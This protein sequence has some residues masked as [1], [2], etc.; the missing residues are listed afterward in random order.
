M[1]FPFDGDPEILCRLIFAGRNHH[2]WLF[3]GCCWNSWN[4][5]QRL[6]KLSSDGGTLSQFEKKKKHLKELH[7]YFAL[8]GEEWRGVV[9]WLRSIP[10]HFFTLPFIDEQQRRGSGA[11]FFSISTFSFLVW[12]TKRLGGGG[13]VH[14]CCV[15]DTAADKR[16]RE[17]LKDLWHRQSRAGKWETAA[18][19]W[20]LTAAV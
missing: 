6:S 5:K 20:P 10:L 12:K 1:T 9:S 16:R 7:G 3:S 18:S 15:A 17:S 13:R 19:S 2:V 8:R 14:S 4:L 11:F